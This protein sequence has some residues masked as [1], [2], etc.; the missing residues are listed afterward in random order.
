MNELEGAAWSTLSVSVQGMVHASQQATDLATVELG[1]VRWGGPRLGKAA[2]SVTFCSACDH[3]TEHYTLKGTL[4]IE[5][6]GSLERRVRW[7]QSEAQKV[8]AYF[9]NFRPKA[10]FDNYLKCDALIR[11]GPLVKNKRAR[12]GELT[13]VRF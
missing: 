5:F 6:S 10:L 7:L 8:G 3:Q 2:A 1:T 4:Y 11:H 12:S 9:R 13:H